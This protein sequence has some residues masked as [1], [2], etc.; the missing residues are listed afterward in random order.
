VLSARV[1][2]VC[3]DARGRFCSRSDV[4][5]SEQR[6]TVVGARERHDGCHWYGFSRVSRTGI[7]PAMEDDLLIEYRILALL[8]LVLS[9]SETT[10]S[11][12]GSAL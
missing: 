10:T 3:G 4:V 5:E 11:I 2:C 8:P 12:S 1:C 6:S 9:G 7:L